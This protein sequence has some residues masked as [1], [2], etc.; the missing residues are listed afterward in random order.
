MSQIRVGFVGA[1]NVTKLHLEGISRHP[2]RA[3][4][5]AFC[6]P[7]E[8]NIAARMET[9]GACDAYS[10][11]GDMISKAE[12]DVAIVCTPTAIRQPV[13]LPLIEARIPTLC[14]KPFTDSYDDAAQI[15][16]AAREAGVPV[17]VNQNFRRNFP[18]YIAREILQMVSF[19]Y[20]GPPKLIL[21]Q[22]LQQFVTSIM[23]V[24][25]RR[26]KKVGPI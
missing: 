1:G 15:E 10:N 13:L 22:F 5:V 6:D 21:I 18:F 4:V 12:I 8:S 24:G 11:L 25:F 19:V 14:E 2:D 26:M 3:K 17:A 16:K 23:R 7:D 20:W 9:F